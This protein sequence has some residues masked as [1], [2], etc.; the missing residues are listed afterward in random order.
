MVSFLYYPAAFQVLVRI[1]AGMRG[2]GLTIVMSPLTIVNN[3]SE[4]RP[5]SRRS[6]DFPFAQKGQKGWDR[7]GGSLPNLA[8]KALDLC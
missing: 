7:K 4:L 3:D 8:L 1:I 2:T 5:E 6:H